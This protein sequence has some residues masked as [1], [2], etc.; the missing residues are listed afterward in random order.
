MDIREL[1]CEL[2]G[3]GSGSCPVADFCI[4]GEERSSST[5]RELVN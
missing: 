5:I 2:D 1:G 3:T 4:S